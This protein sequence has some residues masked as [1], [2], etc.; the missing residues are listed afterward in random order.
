MQMGQGEL[1]QSFL[2]SV[3]ETSYSLIA[4]EMF[5]V[6]YLLYIGQKVT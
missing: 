6:I 3:C 1:R 2:G 5:V 4:S